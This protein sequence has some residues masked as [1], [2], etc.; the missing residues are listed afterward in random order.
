MSN[1]IADPETWTGWFSTD[2]IVS[3]FGCLI[4][5]QP[6]CRTNLWII[7]AHVQAH[8]CALGPNRLH[9]IEALATLMLQG[10]RDPIAS[11]P[12]IYR[13]AILEVL[14]EQLLK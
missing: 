1:V 9:A 5:H 10:H 7:E 14:D 8:I 6:L 12:A 3:S 4:C 11:A 2:G 13:A